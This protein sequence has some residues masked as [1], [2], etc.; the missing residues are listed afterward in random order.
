MYKRRPVSSPFRLD[1]AREQGKTRELEKEG[2][3]Q[4]ERCCLRLFISRALLAALTGD[5]VRDKARQRVRPSG[6][7]RHIGREA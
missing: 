4:G 1:A 2:A 3:L 7:R 6:K 5:R